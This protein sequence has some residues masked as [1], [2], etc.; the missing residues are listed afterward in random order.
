[1]KKITTMLPDEGVTAEYTV[2][3]RKDGDYC[4]VEYISNNEIMLR[5][6]EYPV[7]LD[8][9]ALFVDLVRDTLIKIKAET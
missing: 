2:R 1:V 7:H 8:G 5:S 9:T 4:W 3:V 6:K